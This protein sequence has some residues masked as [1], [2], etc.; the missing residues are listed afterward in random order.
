MFCS[1]NV[2]M[3]CIVVSFLGMLSIVL[4]ANNLELTQES[5]LLELKL[6]LFSQS[7][8]WITIELLL[9]IIIGLVSL[10][11]LFIKIF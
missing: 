6:N 10:C 11:I 3:F 2:I 9:P 1:S 5:S 8:R 7:L 4:I